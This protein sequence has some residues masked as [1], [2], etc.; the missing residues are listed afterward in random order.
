MAIIIDHDA[1]LERAGANITGW[2]SRILFFTRRYPLGAAGAFLVALFVLTAL[3]ADVIAPVDP[4]A[5]NAKYSL[6]KPG[7]LFWLGA[8][9]PP[10]R[11]RLSAH[12]RP[13][14]RMPCWAPRPM[15]PGRCPV[16]PQ[17]GGRRGRR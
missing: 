3:F 7:G 9:L 17:S 12:R 8:Q 16:R 2:W 13:P 11:R 6:A 4:T 14:R 15:S 5:T 1:E 10:C